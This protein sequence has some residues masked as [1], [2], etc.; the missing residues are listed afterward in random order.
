MAT[1]TIDE[2]SIEVADGDSIKDAC[3]QLGVLFGC[4]NGFCRTC[5]IEVLEGYE[6][7]TEISENEEF[8]MLDYPKRL[9]CQCRLLKDGVRI[10]PLWQ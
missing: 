9:A 3:E 8:I 10:K 5:E 7:L 6:N 1:I 2:K 4:R